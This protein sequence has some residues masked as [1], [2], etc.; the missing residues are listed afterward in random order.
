MTTPEKIAVQVGDKI[1]AL[2]PVTIPNPAGGAAG[3]NMQRGAVLTITESFVEDTKDRTGYTWLSD[4]SETAQINRW[5]E[6]RFIVGDASN[7]ILWWE[8]DSSSAKIAFEHE[9]SNASRIADPEERAA[10]VVAIRDK[11]KRANLNPS[12]QQTRRFPGSDPHASQDAR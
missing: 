2:T 7:R 5:G 3:L 10:T 6:Q 4:L 1:T 8:G 9:M 12:N 11:F